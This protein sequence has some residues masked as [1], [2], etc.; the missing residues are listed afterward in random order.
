MTLELNGTAALVMKLL[1]ADVNQATVDVFKSDSF[2]AQK[3]Q[4]KA[5]AEY[6]LNQSL[7]AINDELRSFAIPFPQ[8]L[9]VVTVD[10]AVILYV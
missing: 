2:V 8:Q 5:L 7:P 9:W 3:D 10:A 4:L 6:A 1:D